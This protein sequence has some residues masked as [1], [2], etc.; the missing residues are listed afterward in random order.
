[1][2]LIYFSVFRE[3]LLMFD[4]ATAITKNTI[5]AINEI[6]P[7]MISMRFV[8]LVHPKVNYSTRIVNTMKNVW[9]NGEA[10]VLWFC[11]DRYLKPLQFYSTW[12]HHTPGPSGW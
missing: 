5:S 7:V 3:D 11:R 8:F 2:F 4:S 1:M 6:N 9:I 10:A 12:W